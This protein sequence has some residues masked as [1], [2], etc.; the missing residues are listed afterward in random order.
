MT[1]QHLTES[2][3][4][5]FDDLRGR[6]EARTAR[7]I[8]ECE[9]A[10][11]LVGGQNATEDGIRAYVTHHLRLLDAEAEAAVQRILREEIGEREVPSET[12]ELQE[13]L[14]YGI[15]VIRRDSFG[16]WL[17]NWMAKACLK[18]AAS[19]IGLFAQKRGSKGDMAEMGEVRPHGAS[20]SPS[21][22]A[23]EEC[24]YGAFQRIH[25]L[26]QDSDLPVKTY[27]KEFKGSVNT[28]KG[29]QSIVNTAECAPPGSRFAFEFRYS[30]DKVKENDIAEVFAIAMNIGLGSCK[31]FE[32]GKFIIRK[33][34]LEHSTREK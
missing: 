4:F 1:A 20:C 12:G 28:P 15:N 19:R 30:E 29:R 9:L 10:T 31:A 7:V 21:L 8:A 16:P 24:H 6:Y 27:Y 2:K 26:A 34:T 25:L 33:L 17:G 32:C 11:E 18:A 23:D 3:I 13:K 14:V 5:T 22:V